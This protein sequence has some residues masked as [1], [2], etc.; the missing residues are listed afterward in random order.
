MILTVV[1]IP[2]RVFATLSLVNMNF[3]PRVAHFFAPDSKAL[4]LAEAASLNPSAVAETLYVSL[5]NSRTLL[6]ETH[7][8]KNNREMMAVF[9]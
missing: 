2:I 7:P 1:S 5:P 8:V 4:C 3:L 6:V 9:L